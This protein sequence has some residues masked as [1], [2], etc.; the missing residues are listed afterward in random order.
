MIT[1][2]PLGRIGRI[3][4][5]SVSALTG[6]NA[7][8]EV[9]RLE[10]IVARLGSKIQNLERQLSNAVRMIKQHRRFP[11]QAMTARIDNNC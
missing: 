3:I 9:D 4:R 5:G 11:D 6:I 1:Q 7:A 2:L 10:R 8:N